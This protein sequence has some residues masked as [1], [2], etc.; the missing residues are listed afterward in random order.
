[1][2]ATN[3]APTRPTLSL[4]T[5]SGRLP[6]RGRDDVHGLV[7]AGDNGGVDGGGLRNGIDVDL[8]LPS[9]LVVEVA[10]IGVILS[11]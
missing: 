9:S 10:D 11:S 4:P 3:N 6:W 2:H 7:L 1:M 5:L 8:L